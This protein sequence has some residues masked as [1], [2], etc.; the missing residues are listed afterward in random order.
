MIHIRVNI[1]ISTAL[2][3]SG[4]TANRVEKIVFSLPKFSEFHLIGKKYG[5]K[6]RSSIWLESGYG[7]IT[8]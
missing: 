3:K 8:P 5:R 4:N 6:I 2:I 7:Y 1:F